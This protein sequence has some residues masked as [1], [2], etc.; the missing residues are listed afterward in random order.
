M[1][2]TLIATGICMSIV[3]LAVATETEA[4]IARPIDIPAESLDRALQILAQQCGLTMA[5]RS[6]VVGSWRSGEVYGELTRDQA[7]TRLLSGTGL[8]FKYIDA[9]TVT[10]VPASAGA[11]AVVWSGSS[12]AATGPSQDAGEQTPEPPLE[13]VTVTGSR[14]A[15][16]ETAFANPVVSVSA[17]TIKLSGK[18]NVA[19]FLTRSPALVGSNV[20]DLTGG[21]GSATGQ[22]GLNLLN[23]RNLGTDRTLVLV[24]GR[25]HV[26]GL[27]GSAAVDIAA[28]PTDL[29]ESVDVLTGG[30]SAIYGAD[31]VSGVVNFRMKKDFEGFTT[32]AQVG[33]SRYGDGMNRFAALTW[34]QNFSD[35][36]GNIAVA[37][38]FNSDDRVFDQ[39]RP[40]MQQKHARGLYQNQADP[41]DDPNVPDNVIYRDV[42]FS[43]TGTG[44]AFDVDFDSSSD[45]EGSGKPWDPGM[46]LIGGGGLTVGG[47]GTP[48]AGY[49]GDMFPK[50][51][52]HLVNVI[53]HFDFSD[54]FSAFFEGKYATA[55]VKTLWQPS[56][57]VDMFVAA[58]NPYMPQSIR[59]AIVPG[60]AAEWYGEGTADGVSMS[61][62]DF[63]LGTNGE[64]AKRD[65]LRWVV[66][67]NGAL[68]DHAKYEISYV[69]GETRS[70]INDINNRITTRWL[71]AADVVRDPLSGNPVCRSS[72]DPN[73][74]P[75]LAG[76]VP[77]NVFGVRKVDPAV[78]G[79]VNAN[80]LNRSLVT[81]SVVSGSISGNF[82][83]FLKLPGGPIGY[84]V[85]AE[86]RRETSEFNPDPRI[87]AG[88]TW[89]A[90][91]KYTKGSLAVKE[92]FSEIALPV[93]ENQRFAQT[94]SFGGAIRLSDYD[95]IG[96]ATTW[97][98]DG[99]YAPVKSISFRGTYSQAVRAPNIGELFAAPGT[100]EA[101]IDD[102]C[103]FRQLNNGTTSRA[104]NCAA[105]LEPLGIDPATFSPSTGAQA[106][107]SIQGITGGNRQLAA[108]TAKTW[109]AGVVLRPSFLPAFTMTL[110][111][112]DIK[113]N[114]AISTSPP[115]AL[116]NLCVDQPTL[117]NPFCGA[118]T[119]NPRNGL[120]VG[121][122]SQPEN[123]AAF[124]TAGF[125]LTLSYQVPTENLGTFDFSMIGGYLDRL[126]TIPT[127]GA[128]V[129]D[130][131]NQPYR[132][133]K[134]A[135]LDVTWMKGAWTLAYNVDWFSR[136]L[137]YAANITAGDPDYAAS[138]YLRIKAK[139][140]HNLQ[141]NYE[142][143]KDLSVYV[144]V[145]NIFN[146]K[147][148]FAYSSYPVSGMGTFLYA[149][150]QA[151]L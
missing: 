37:Y 104:A 16:P 109:T 127:P 90:D 124:T 18:T 38:E 149:G 123:V 117:D 70:R 83:S 3:G 96:K 26:S 25:R 101:F 43:N 60:A 72:L 48:L 21:S 15:R 55:K 73:A 74:D 29:I 40:W 27:A 110:D 111:W 54:R 64:M 128:E 77:F 34:G 88:E 131:R 45:F 57:D 36:R 93:L 63:D 79:F 19:E 119:R 86:Y 137:R 150:V 121:W 41:D 14:I 139:W 100:S 65:T 84:A 95:T 94:L 92:L 58:D 31:G 135:N 80:S 99:V 134:V 106:S 71:A 146:E 151:A 112:Y 17:A 91:L 113:I 1:R 136:T 61:R 85:G 133:K 138:N 108:E 105:L 89:V 12:L 32:R 87:A 98:L 49:Q 142:F 81:Q 33:Q 67:A 148:D 145:N 46:P 51:E 143:N 130:E 75:D 69:Y 13:E 140:E 22:A 42:R 35:G 52:R 20:G 11:S 28:I 2:A 30:A 120:I 107:I 115:E 62:D 114:K 76:C 126:T 6:E 44:G 66:G 97:K 118:I 132:P 39:K 10:I 147:P 141:A 24:D 4:A 9:N 116:A 103:D 122:E 129:V 53:G 59:D 82:G 144:G 102:P 5:Y 78:L 68:S 8:A 56:F 23:L 125:D 47:S 7:L 50:L